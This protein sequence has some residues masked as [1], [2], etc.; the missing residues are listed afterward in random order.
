[1]ICSKQLFFR[2]DEWP[3]QRD[4]LRELKV[5]N[6]LFGDASLITLEASISDVVGESTNASM[7]YTR[8]LRLS[9]Q[10]WL[11]PGWILA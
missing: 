2:I 5:A 9:E 7:L 3:L 4:F 10:S 8:L 1:M 11:I 6:D